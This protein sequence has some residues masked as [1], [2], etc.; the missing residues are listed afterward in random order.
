[1]DEDSLSLS[2]HSSHESS[3]L[4]SSSNSSLDTP[5]SA[6]VDIVS[7]HPESTHPESVDL[8]SVENDPNDFKTL[9]A[10]QRPQ[11]ATLHEERRI[12]ELEREKAALK[13]DVQVKEQQANL[14]QMEVERR[15][16]RISQLEAQ[17]ADLQQS[18]EKS[19][20][21]E[22]RSD[23]SLDLEDLASED[24]SMEYK[25]P[26]PHRSKKKGNSEGTPSTK[27]CRSSSS[28]L[29]FLEA[30]HVHRY[31]KKRR[32]GSSRESQQATREKLRE[33]RNQK[34]TRAPVL[35]GQNSSKLDDLCAHWQTEPRNI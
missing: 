33:K 16:Q 29:D 9:Q 15:A 19:L 10:P 22:N 12:Q 34:E 17:N 4:S 6:S 18:V 20:Q 25:K 13:R 27:G 11:L 14:L 24:S 2:S 28:S 35:A 7:T 23:T 5:T 31:G 26:S 32:S 3:S 1:M 8:R 30:H 21:L